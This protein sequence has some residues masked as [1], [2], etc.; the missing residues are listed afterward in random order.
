METRI[1]ATGGDIT[2]GWG[3]RHSVAADYLYDYPVQLG[4]LRAGP[5]LA[6]IG[7][8]MAN[9]KL[10]FAAPLRTEK[11][12]S[13]FRDAAVQVLFEV[14]KVGATPSPDALNLPKEFAPARRLRSRAET[15]SEAT[16]GVSVELRADVPLYE[17]PFTPATPK[18]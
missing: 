15:G 10:Q 16:R 13:K 3:V 17:A 2:R 9:E 12:E 18:K 7:V 8:R 1:I 14:R 4:S 6:A 5:D 11:R